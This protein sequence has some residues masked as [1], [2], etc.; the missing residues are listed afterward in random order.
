VL[1]VR[2]GVAVL[3]AGDVDRDV[4]ADAGETVE[5]IRGDGFLEPGHPLIGQR[6]GDT[7]GLFGVVGAVGVHVQG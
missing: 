4:V 7:D 5:V 2:E 6:G 1:E 3:A